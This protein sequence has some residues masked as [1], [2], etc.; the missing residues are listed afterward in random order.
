ML[1]GWRECG[2]PKQA[3]CLWSGHLCHDPV[4]LHEAGEQ[5]MKLWRGRLSCNRDPIVSES[6]YHW[7]VTVSKFRHPVALAQETVWD[8]KAAELGEWGYQSPWESKESLKNPRCRRCIYGWSGVCP[9]GFSLD[10]VF[11]S[12][13]SMLSSMERECSICGRWTI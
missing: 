5:C 11:P 13:V 3:E 6:Q 1:Q 12:L 8:L 2:G 7:M 10:F 9:V 4:S